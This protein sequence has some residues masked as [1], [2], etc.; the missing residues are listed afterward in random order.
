MSSDSV[1]SAPLPGTADLETGISKALPL[2]AGDSLASLKLGMLLMASL[3]SD[4]GFLRIRQVRRKPGQRDARNF[5]L[6]GWHV[7]WLPGA[8]PS[9][10]ELAQCTQES[11]RRQGQLT[12]PM[13]REGSARSRAGLLALLIA[14][15]RHNILDDRLYVVGWHAEGV[16]VCDNSDRLLGAIHDDLT[17][18]AFTQ[19]LFETG[20]EFRTGRIFQVIPELGQK[21]SATEHRDSCSPG[22]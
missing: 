15:A 22:E 5:E 18:L 20:A 14:N 8:I 9:P 6:I 4:R 21:I 3:L 12:S 11:G 13:R 16:A 1:L 19:M 7:V 2:K 10:G 17:G